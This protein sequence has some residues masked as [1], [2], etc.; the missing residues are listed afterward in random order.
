MM[1]FGLAIARN[2][3]YNVSGEFSGLW[4]KADASRRQ[5]GPRNP[6]KAP[7]SMVRFRGKT[8]QGRKPL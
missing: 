2:L 4:L 8:I 1:H 5:S 3:R 6:A 7:V